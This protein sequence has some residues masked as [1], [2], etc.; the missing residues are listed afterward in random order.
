IEPGAVN[1][2]ADIIAAPR[3]VPKRASPKRTAVTCNAGT[4][5]Q[6][7]L[8]ISV[9]NFVIVAKASA[10]EMAAYVA[11][12][13]SGQLAVA[14]AGARVESSVSSVYLL[15]KAAI[16]PLPLVKPG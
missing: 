14:R 9:G 15:Q 7:W 4:E 12:V 10:A 13:P 6:S 5:S 1:T 2:Q 11:L 8:C 3:S 16:F